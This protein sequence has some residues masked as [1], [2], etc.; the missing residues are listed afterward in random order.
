MRGKA[1]GVIVLLRADPQRASAHFLQDFDKRRDA[2]RRSPPF[3]AHKRIG[4]VAKKV[5]VGSREARKLPSRHRMTAKKKRAALLR[6]II[7]RQKSVTRN[8]VL[9]ASVT[10]ACAGAWR[11]ISGSKSR[12][13]RWAARCRQDRRR[14]GP[15]S[16]GP[17]K[18][19]FD[20]AGFPAST[21]NFAAV[22]AGDVNVRRV[23]AQRQ[24]ERAADQAGAENGGAL[25]KMGEAMN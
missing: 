1:D 3:G 15:A 2:G 25:D 18:T 24:G 13:R 5:G 12:V 21:R 23:F 10:R 19:S 16:S 9:Q 17:E 11:A 4:S 6:E 20:R 8:L 7:R 22:P 14:A